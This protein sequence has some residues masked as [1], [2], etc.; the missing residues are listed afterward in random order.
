MTGRVD[1]RHAFAPTS[2]AGAKREGAFD[3][4]V[5][6]LHYDLDAG[7]RLFKGLGF[8]VTPRSYHTLGSMN[9]LV[10]FGN[11]YLEL[12]GLDPSNPNPR[13]ELLDWPIGLNGFVY[14]SDDIDVTAARLRASHLPALEP[15]AFSREV[16]IAG[17]TSE[18][19]FRTVHLD[20][21][22][23]QAGRIYFCEHQTP[24]LV[25]HKAFISHPNSARHLERLVVVADDA[26]A[27]AQSVARALGLEAGPDARIRSGGLQIDFVSRS[28]LNERYRDLAC[29]APAGAKVAVMTIGVA[30]FAALKGAMEPRLAA[31]LF[32]CGDGR[33]VLP[34]AECFGVAVEFV[35]TDVSLS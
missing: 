22:Y 6:N 7:E 16:T 9:N 32:D 13:K 29:P 3:H 14:A 23:F 12:I 18:A 35:T 11:D 10:V 25:W 17:V 21:K 30:S 24:E 19:R 2:G 4:A 28:R 15:K 31:K 27:Q 1:G 34:A 8:N 20:P 33:L 5:F 26:A